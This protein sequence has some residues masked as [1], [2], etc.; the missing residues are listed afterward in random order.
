MPLAVMLWM[1]QA[2]MACRA[3]QVSHSQECSQGTTGTASWGR[4][5]PL[6]LMASISSCRSI[7]LRCTANLHLQPAPGHR[8]LI[9][10]AATLSPLWQA[11]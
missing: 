8:A 11:D 7:A 5:G 4:H 6:C 2:H 1:L 9:I 3:A 10:R